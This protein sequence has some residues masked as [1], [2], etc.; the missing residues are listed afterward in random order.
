MRTH[1]TRFYS[2]AFALL[3]LIIS[4]MSSA[5]IS[6]SSPYSY[7]NEEEHALVT[8]NHESLPDSA[9]TVLVDADS[10]KITSLGLG[11]GTWGYGLNVEIEN[12]SDKYI[13]VQSRGFAINGW[14]VSV[15]FSCDVSPY[16]TV[17]DTMVFDLEQMLMAGIENI[18]LIQ[19]QIWSIPGNDYDNIYYSD[20]ITIGN[21]TYTPIYPDIEGT[22]VY[23]SYG[24]KM[25]VPDAGSFD[26]GDS[27]ALPIYLENNNDVTIDMNMM[28]IIVDGHTM[29]VY[30]GADLLPHTRSISLVNDYESYVTFYDI[31]DYE[32]IT[33]EFFVN[34]IDFSLSINPDPITV[35]FD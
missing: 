21:S 29:N 28:T 3:F 8:E 32:E 6:M 23:N 30:Y 15:Y 16:T 12:K 13:T 35:T 34:S 20:I 25:L 5:A 11:D 31:G 24:F 27:A 33:F 1:L 18:E 17:E 9:G 19:M 2:P 22:T 14:S 4:F 10:I 7:L 26:T